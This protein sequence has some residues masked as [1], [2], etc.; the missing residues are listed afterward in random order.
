[1]FQTMDD[2]RAA[3][4]AIGNHWFDSATKRFFRSRIGSTLYGG[5]Y[6]V[7]SEQFDDNSPRL[8]TIRIAR[9]NGSISTVGSFQQYASRIDTIRAIENLIARG[10]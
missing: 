8:Y 10:I 1:M 9:D 4:K 7:S 2:V 3:N 5:K 6:F